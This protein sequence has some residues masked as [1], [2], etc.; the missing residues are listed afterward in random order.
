MQGG[1]VSEGCG[2]VQVVMQGLRG[3]RA[4]GRLQGG[5]SQERQ[6]VREVL[7]TGH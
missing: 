4:C 5:R 3:Q 7:L 1:N 2:V 6:G